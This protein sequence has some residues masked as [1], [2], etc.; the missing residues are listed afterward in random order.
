MYLKKV[1]ETDESRI[2]ALQ[3]AIDREELNGDEEIILS[4][5]EMQELRTF[6]T[7][8]EGVGFVMQQAEKDFAQSQTDYIKLFDT[9]QM[10][11]SHFIQVLQL[12]TIRDEIKLESLSDY[13]FESGKE[14]ELPDL[15]TEEAVIYWGEKMI[16]GEAKRMSRGGYPLYNPTIAKVKVHYELFTDIVH[17]TKIYRQ[18]VERQQTALQDLQHKAESMIRDIWSRVEEKYASMPIQELSEIYQAYKINYHYQK[19]VR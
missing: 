7:S 9:A 10:Y 16:Q 14:M 2:E 3:A 8:Y 18:N 5:E 12:T 17:S 13:G 1:P 15:S 4:L 19:D 11:V 6:V